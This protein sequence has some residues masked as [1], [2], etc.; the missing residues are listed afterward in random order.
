MKIHLKMILGKE[1]F[2][3]IGL[4]SQSQITCHHFQPIIISDFCISLN[5]K[6]I[7]LVIKTQIHCTPSLE[8]YSY[9]FFFFSY[10]LAPLHI[11]VGGICNYLSSHISMVWTLQ[12]TFLLGSLWSSL[13]LAQTLTGFPL[14]APNKSKS[15]NDVGNSG[16]F[17]IDNFFPLEFICFLKDIPSPFSI[18]I[19]CLLF[20]FT[21]QVL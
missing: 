1:K 2:V 18:H 6:T 3:R 20:S 8:K 11:T 21:Q 17:Y 10:P 9:F 19:V 12:S 13:T 4:S 15:I 7:I 14:L 16:Y 5:K